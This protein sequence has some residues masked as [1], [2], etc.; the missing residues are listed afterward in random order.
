MIFLFPVHYINAVPNSTFLKD[1][2][3][4]YY[5]QAA[6]K[7]GHLLNGNYKNWKNVYVC[8]FLN[9]IRANQDKSKWHV[10]FRCLN[11]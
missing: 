10:F 4:H 6:L 8:R 11:L 9:N 5:D 3:K 7:L 2:N 1:K